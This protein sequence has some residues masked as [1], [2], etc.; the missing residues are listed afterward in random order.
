MLVLA[1][2]IIGVNVF[3]VLI[4]GIISGIVIM[5]VMGEVTLRLC[6]LI[7]EVVRQ[8]CLRHVWL[9]FLYL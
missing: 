2:G 8:E 4:T 7:W 1:G 9:Q 5:L 3:V 6:F